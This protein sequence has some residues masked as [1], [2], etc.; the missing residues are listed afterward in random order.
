MGQEVQRAIIL[1]IAVIR[2]NRLRWKW[3]LGLR[4]KANPL[5]S[6]IA[7][8]NYKLVAPKQ[9]N[10]NQVLHQVMVMILVK[11]LRVRLWIVKTTGTAALKE[12]K[13]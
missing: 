4:I 8:T 1:K 7:L 10:S 11:V 3:K 2:T 13:V 6:T 5:I 12:V 9:A